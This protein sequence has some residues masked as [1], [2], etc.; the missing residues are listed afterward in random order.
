MRHF[1]AV[2]EG[3]EWPRCRSAG[4]TTMG[5][6]DLNFMCCLARNKAASTLPTAGSCPVVDRRGG[7]WPLFCVSLMSRIR[8]VTSC[9]IGR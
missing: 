2:A 8:D 7:N 5:W 4:E 9:M 1:G 3:T 6:I